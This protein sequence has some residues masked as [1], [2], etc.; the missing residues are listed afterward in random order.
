MKLRRLIKRLLSILL[1]LAL[2]V[3][4]V[5]AFTVFNRPDGSKHVCQGVRVDIADQTANG[6]ITKQE[7]VNRLKA[8]HLYP[9]EQQMSMVDI[10]SIEEMLQQSPFVEKAE[11][12]KSQDDCVNI[13]ITQ[14]LPV[15]RVKANNGDDYYIDSKDSIMPNTQYCSDLIIATGHINHHF[16]THSLAPL[17]RILME[18][19]L[20]RS[21]IEQINILSDNSV[22]LVPR[23]GSHIVYIGQLP[24]NVTDAKLRSFVEKKLN[25]LVKFYRYGLPQAGWN[26]YSYINLEFD[27][28]I[29]CTRR[30]G[31]HEEVPIPLIHDSLAVAPQAPAVAN[32]SANNNNNQ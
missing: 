22:E 9:K 23:V 30:S 17:G 21:L 29:I 13:S 16:A 15:I 27:N 18:N 32:D 10:R 8:S 14:R 26:K 4:L 12:Y 28:Q 19:S 3:Y 1:G 6:F 11:C 7:V 5:L 31:T 2:I 20:W 25:R 24:T